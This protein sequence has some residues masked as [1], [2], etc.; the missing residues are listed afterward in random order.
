MLDG[1][2]KG[3]KQV[4]LVDMSHYLLVV[5]VRKSEVNLKTCKLG[6]SNTV[7]LMSIFLQ[8]ISICKVS[9]TVY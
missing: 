6:K 7:Q 2:N 9:R 4:F 1:E 5:N 8:I 3:N